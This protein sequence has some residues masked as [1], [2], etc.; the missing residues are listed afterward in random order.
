MRISGQFAF[1]ILSL[2]AVA[3]TG[4]ASTRSVSG[5]NTQNNTTE[6][7]ASNM[8]LT[9]KNVTQ[10]LDNHGTNVSESQLT[11]SDPFKEQD[12]IQKMNLS[13]TLK[14]QD[15]DLTNKN[16]THP[17]SSSPQASDSP[18]ANDGN[19]ICK[20][21]QKNS[22]KNSDDSKNKDGTGNKEQKHNTKSDINSIKD[23]IKSDIK[24]RFK[25]P[26]DIPFP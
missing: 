15:K 19:G 22:K 23:K 20:D 3:L 18:C 12:S 25:L 26:I 2:L 8:T 5:L 4:S 17:S 11:N 13:N 6:P 10:K 14:S 7:A 16:K 24:N 21:N 9:S 1:L